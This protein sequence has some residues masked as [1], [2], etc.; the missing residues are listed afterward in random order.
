MNTKTFTIKRK[1]VIAAAALTLTFGSLGF[2]AAKAEGPSGFGGANFLACSTTDSAAVIGTALNLTAP[3]VRLAV[4]SGRSLQQLATQQNV[5]INTVITALR[6]AL[7]AD[8]DQAVADGLLTSQQADQ[9]KARLQSTGSNT[10]NPSQPGQPGQGNP[11]GRGRGGDGRDGR[12]GFGDRGGPGRGGLGGHGGFMFLG[13]FARNQSNP[14][15]AAATALDMTCPALVKELQNGKSVLQV[16]QEKGVSLDSLIKAV[17][18][19][20][21]AATNKDLAE[22]L[23]AKVEADQQIAEAVNRAA[24]LLSQDKDRPGFIMGIFGDGIPGMPMMP[25]MPGNSQGGT[26]EAP[27]PTATPGQ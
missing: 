3:E 11:G 23:I 21:I 2:S 25:G 22:G 12:G 5:D 26:P 24:R 14:M 4:A 16:A 10:Q 13:N 19:D 6:N 7:I 9:F 18:D 8:I 17:A 1:F 20:L 27:A 15:I